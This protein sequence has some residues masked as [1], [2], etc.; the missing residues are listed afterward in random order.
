M[1]QVG[2]YSEIED[3]FKRLLSEPIYKTDIKD[4]I[5][6]SISVLKASV[7]LVV[8]L[9]TASVD[10]P[11][12]WR[13]CRRRRAAPPSSTYLYELSSNWVRDKAFVACLTC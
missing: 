11:Y 10:L 6:L 1:E 2:T 4:I 12:D 13:D 5:V 8:S 7:Q 9:N 3:L